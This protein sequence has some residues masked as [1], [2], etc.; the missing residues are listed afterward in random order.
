MNMYADGIGHFTG[1]LLRC[2]YIPAC[3]VCVQFHPSMHKVRFNIRQR[4]AGRQG[5][6]PH[7]LRSNTSYKR[8]TG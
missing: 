5:D 8:L 2:K 4:L 6:W 1:H 7:H 3:C